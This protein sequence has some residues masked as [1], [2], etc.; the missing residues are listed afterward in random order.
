MKFEI[1]KRR[2]EQS[3][4][5]VNVTFMHGDDDVRDHEEFGPMDETVFTL[6]CKAL[7]RMQSIDDIEDSIERRIWEEESELCE[8][9][10]LRH[11]YNSEPQRFINEIPEEDLKQY[12]DPSIFNRIKAIEYNHPWCEFTDHLASI[13][14]FSAVYV[15]DGRRYEV[16]L[17][18]E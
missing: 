14:D 3:G 13:W 1:I 15:E 16:E 10:Y 4:F 7:H 12:L 5:Y 6:F 17:S 2:K 18:F 8:P 9:C 11:R